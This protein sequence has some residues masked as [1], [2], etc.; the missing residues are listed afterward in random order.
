MSFNKRQ[1]L[2]TYDIR[3]VETMCAPPATSSYTGAADAGPPGKKANHLPAAIHTAYDIAAGWHS[4]RA[5]MTDS[6][7]A[8]SEIM[9]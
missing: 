1:S 6:I 3:P 7:Q 4:P 2:H 5:S 8:G 9:N